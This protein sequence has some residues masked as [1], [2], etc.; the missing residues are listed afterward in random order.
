MQKQTK[1]QLKKEIWRWFKK[2]QTIYL[3]TVLGKK[4]QVRPMAMIYFK[5][6]FWVMT[7]TRD[8][9]VKQIK[10]NRNV[11]YCLMLKRGKRQ[12]YIRA[13]CL[14]RIVKDRK[15]RHSLANNVFFF[16][17]YWKSADEKSYTLIELKHKQIEYER[18]GWLC[19]KTIKV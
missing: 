3:A 6:K 13:D 5:H 17:H 16:R 14:A 12:G 15:T 7:G 10:K 11:Q 18:P 19:V 9:K 1:S 2:F 8:A 4:P